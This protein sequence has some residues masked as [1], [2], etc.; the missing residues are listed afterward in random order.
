MLLNVFK[1]FVFLCYNNCCT[2]LLGLLRVRCLLT[3]ANKEF[4]ADP[5][6]LAV[7]VTAGSGPPCG[8]SCRL[9]LMA[10]LPWVIPSMYLEDLPHYI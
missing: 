4:G 7:I 8:S 2:H 1:Y 3:S 6:E 5:T 10:P 9:P